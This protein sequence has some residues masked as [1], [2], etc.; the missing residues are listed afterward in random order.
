MP[1][2]SKT[3]RACESY[4]P[5]TRTWLCNLQGSLLALQRMLTLLV[6]LI[7]VRACRERFVQHSQLRQQG[8]QCMQ[9]AQPARHLVKSRPLHKSVPPADGYMLHRQFPR[10]LGFAFSL[11]AHMAHYMPAVP[12]GRLHLGGGW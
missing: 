1:G 6:Y 5:E 10:L 4:R 12:K 9:S 2:T 7:Y 8:M 3:C 11:K